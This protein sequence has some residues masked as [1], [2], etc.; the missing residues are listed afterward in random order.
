ML[1][2]DALENDELGRCQR[3]YRLCQARFVS[4]SGVF[5]DDALLHGLINQAER[6]GKN[7]FCVF[8][9]SGFNCSSEFSHLR[10]E[11]VPVGLVESFEFQALTMSL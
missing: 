2:R 7:C 6:A 4:A 8:R 3:V 10:F 11:L 9:F 1:R 5:L